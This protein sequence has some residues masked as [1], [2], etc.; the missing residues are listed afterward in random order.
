MRSVD[1]GCFGLVSVVVEVN[2]PAPPSKAPVPWT[3]SFSGNAARSRNRYGAALVRRS[4]ETRSVCSCVGEGVGEGVG[5]ERSETPGEGSGLLLHAVV[6][7]VALRRPPA[8]SVRI[9]ARFTR[10]LWCVASTPA[11]LRVDGC[12]G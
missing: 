10:T 7:S 11:V 3:L 9:D 1:D 5:R 12:S 8:R 2:F 4:A 6:T